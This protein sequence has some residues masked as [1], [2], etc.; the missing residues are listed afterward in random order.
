M[1]I[2][3]KLAG[4]S[5]LNKPLPADI[6][7]ILGLGKVGM[8]KYYTTV[9]HDRQDRPWRHNEIQQECLWLEM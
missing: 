3:D 4:E 7:N 8:Q 5:W 1:V 2:V 9:C 6:H